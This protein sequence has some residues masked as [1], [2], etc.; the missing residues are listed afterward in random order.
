M[1]IQMRGGGGGV[2]RLREPDDQGWMIG[3][4]GRFCF[5]RGLWGGVCEIG[6]GVKNWVLVVKVEFWAWLYRL[7]LRAALVVGV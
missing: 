7:D 3:E 1:E 6:S 5:D 4:N 2:C